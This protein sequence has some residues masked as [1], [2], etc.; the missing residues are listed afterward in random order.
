MIDSG[1]DS[2]TTL[3]TTRRTILAATGAVTLGGLA[4]C[5][6][7]TDQETEAGT[8]TETPT[9]TPVTSMPDGLT[10]WLHPGSETVVGED[11][12]ET[13]R[14]D[15]GN[16]N[17]LG[18]SVGDYRPALVEDAV[19]GT[20]A[21]A[22]DGEDDHLL[23]EDTVGVS[24]GSPRTFVVVAALSDRSARSPMLTQGTYGSNGAEVNH[25]GIEANTF[26][27]SGNRFG[28]FLVDAAYDTE[29]GTDTEY[30]VHTLRT[31]TF[32]DAA[33]V[34]SSTTYYVD[35]SETAIQVTASGD[36]SG[37]EFAGDATALGSFA[38][39]SP[40]EVMHGSIAE[41]RVYDRALADDERAFVES[42]LLDEYDIQSE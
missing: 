29:R 41:V 21:L 11:G 16:G 4:G 24:N 27:T 13:W 32:P 1:P 18:Q 19:A 37:T 17:D 3:H 30:H 39:P 25:Y 8:A 20:A 33:A 22:F 35:G 6:G 31:E 15:S 14:D 2:D 9:R 12:V 36:S 34:Q 28:A 26:G 23:R 5:T 7:L 10:L 42:A 38:L 40:S